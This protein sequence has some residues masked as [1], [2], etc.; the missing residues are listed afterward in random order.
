[1]EHP[2]SLYH[3]SGKPFWFQ[4]HAGEMM[5]IGE[6]RF[7]CQYCKVENKNKGFFYQTAQKY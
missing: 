1:M 3:N 5:H 4:Q 2:T 6:K 7:S